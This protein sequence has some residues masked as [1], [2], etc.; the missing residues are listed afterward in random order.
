MRK[1]SG[2]EGRRIDYPS[3]SVQ[4]RRAKSD[5][6]LVVSIAATV[7]MTLPARALAAESRSFGM[8]VY[9]T[10]FYIAMAGLPPAAGWVADTAGGAATALGV[11]AAFFGA[12]ILAVAIY[13]GLMARRRSGADAS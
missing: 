13:G 12:A 8:G 11:A 3:Y 9:W 1:G 10:I 6:L 7:I 4:P 2:R 5:S